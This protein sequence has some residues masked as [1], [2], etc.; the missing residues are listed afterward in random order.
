MSYQQAPQHSYPPPGYGTIYP[1]PAGYP[2]APPQPDG[3]PYPPPSALI[4][5]KIIMFI[6]TSL[7]NGS[8][9]VL[10]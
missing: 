10:P 4:A 9:Q 8:L 5:H 6:Y 7:D 2:S 1:P 3:Y